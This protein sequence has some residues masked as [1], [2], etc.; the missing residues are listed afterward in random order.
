LIPLARSQSVE[1][2]T[3]NLLQS[4]FASSGDDV[5]QSSA[6]WPDNLLRLQPTPSLLAQSGSCPLCGHRTGY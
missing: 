6:S 2:Q 5:A 4:R 1:Q 3:V